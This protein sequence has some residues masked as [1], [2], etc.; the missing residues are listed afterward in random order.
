[1]LNRNNRRNNMKRAIIILLLI[2]VATFAQQKGSFIDARDGKKYKTVKIGTQTW[3]AENLNY[4]ARGSK[5]GGTNNEL[6]NENTRY[7]DKYGR[8]YD[9][10][11]AMKACPEGWHLPSKEEWN[12]LMDYALS[13]KSCK[14]NRGYINFIGECLGARGWNDATDA[15]GFAALP[16]G[17]GHYDHVY[18][19]YSD[20]LEVG[21]N[22][23]WWS[24]SEVELK[25]NIGDPSEAYSR[26]MMYHYGDENW[27]HSFKDYRMYS[28][29]CIQGVVRKKKGEQK[30]KY[31]NGKLAVVMNYE[32]GV[33]HGEWK[34][35]FENGELSE[36]GNYKEGK[37]HGEQKIFNESG[38]LHSINNYEDGILHGE[39]K[40]FF[41]G[42][43]NSISNYK[44]GKPHGEQKTFDI[45]GKLIKTEN[46]I[47]GVKQKE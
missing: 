17:Y 6:T 18:N 34:K 8:L 16:G 45:N 41:V 3:M 37:L 40:T 25:H 5:C 32:D 10:T 47:D 22:G 46:Y 23:I 35:F 9:W 36:V 21:N 30:W 7:C 4:E 33:P 39:Q 38:N 44:D 43:L 27:S 42:M 2:C 19:N 29:R 13:S 1:M 11:T 14:S 15:Y 12:K 26:N 24:A 20:F 28:V 31:D